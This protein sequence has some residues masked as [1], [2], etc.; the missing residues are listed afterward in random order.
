MTFNAINPQEKVYG[1]LRMFSD[2]TRT[3]V[4]L[5]YKRTT[6]DVYLDAA[7]FILLDEIS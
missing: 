5:D 6:S 1:V 3:K 4:V 2:I 7:R